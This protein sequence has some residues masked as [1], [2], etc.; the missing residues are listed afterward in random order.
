MRFK[1]SFSC[2]FSRRRFKL[3][4][5]QPY[6]RRQ[7]VHVSW[8]QSICNKTIKS[9]KFITIAANVT[10]CFSSR[11]LA[12]KSHMLERTKIITPD[13]NKKTTNDQ[14][15]LSE[16]LRLITKAEID[17]LR[18]VMKHCVLQLHCMIS[19]SNTSCSYF[20]GSCA[21]ITTNFKWSQLYCGESRK[22]SVR[23]IFIG[24]T[25]A[26]TFSANNSY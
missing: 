15:K 20:R 4:V 12:D 19:N 22:I 25:A 8:L 14:K 11:N 18:R 6:W 7:A 26:Q 23:C 3:L 21:T 10:D 2:S 24:Q 5:Y 9:L 13:S 1:T 17:F 16:A